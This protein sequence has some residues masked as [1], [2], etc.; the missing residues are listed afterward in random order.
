MEHCAPVCGKLLAVVSRR[1]GYYIAFL[2][3]TLEEGGTEKGA[4]P[5]SMA[6]DVEI[7]EGRKGRKE[8]RTIFWPCLVL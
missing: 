4:V 6:S 3:L 1:G 8:E 7:R 5:K 2:L